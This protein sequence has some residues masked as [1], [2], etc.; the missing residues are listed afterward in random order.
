MSYF[1]KSLRKTT[2]DVEDIELGMLKYIC[3]HLLEFKVSLG[4]KQRLFLRSEDSLLILNREGDPNSTV[5]MKDKWTKK[6]TDAFFATFLQEQRVN[7]DDVTF[8]YPSITESGVSWGFLKRQLPLAL[9]EY[10]GQAKGR[11]HVVTQF[12]LPYLDNEPSDN[13][14]T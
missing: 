1:G 12:I 9:V 11:E 14:T 7:L 8:H 4:Y 2:L 6:A 3:A 13:T 5:T 10:L